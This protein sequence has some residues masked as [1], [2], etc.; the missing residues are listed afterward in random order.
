MIL[1]DIDQLTAWPT[2]MFAVEA[3][4]LLDPVS[5]YLVCR[6]L[7]RGHAYRFLFGILNLPTFNSFVNTLN[8]T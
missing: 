5:R 6:D 4:E 3:F 8:L 2:S 7:Y 1:S